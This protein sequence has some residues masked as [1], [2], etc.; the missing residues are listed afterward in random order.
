MKDKKSLVGGLVRFSFLERLKKTTLALVVSS[1]LL[2]PANAFEINNT[3]S[4]KEV[5]ANNKP[6]V[7]PAE[8]EV[9]CLAKNIYFEARGESYLGQ[10][11]IAFV[12]LNRVKS[13]AFPN[14]VCDV[15]YQRSSGRCQFQ[16]V[17]M[18]GLRVVDS[19]AFEQ[20][21]QLAV[22]VLV[23]Y[24]ELSDPSRGAL[25]FHAKNV[26]NMIRSSRI[27]ATIGQHR[28]YK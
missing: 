7:I 2:N 4:Y 26:Q 25:Y 19:M 22:K 24:N 23:A 15:V 11:A 18:K 16:W 3:V 14:N 17:C 8:H 28:F 13:G 12:T 20:A 9:H 27:T 6:P 1:L 21:K 10:K 5:V